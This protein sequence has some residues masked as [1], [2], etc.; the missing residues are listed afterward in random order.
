MTHEK[1][2]MFFNIW[3]IE[4]KVFSDLSTQNWKAEELVVDWQVKFFLFLVEVVIRQ[5]RILCVS[6][7]GN[8]LLTHHKQISLVNR[9]LVFW[10][11]VDFDGLVFGFDDVTVVY[12]LIDHPGWLVN[13]LNIVIFVSNHNCVEVRKNLEIIYDFVSRKDSYFWRVTTSIDRK[14]GYVFLETTKIKLVFFIWVF[15]MPYLL[16][17]S[18]FFESKFTE[19]LIIKVNFVSSYH[20]NTR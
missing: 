17:V 7:N 12:L 14:D 20:T 4:A 9:K 8:F 5:K 13:Q 3:A 10:N 6:L 11:F 16:M 15:E 18:K 19:V 2:V 1:A